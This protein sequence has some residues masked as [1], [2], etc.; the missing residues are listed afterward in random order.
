MS[1]ETVTR[2]P[3]RFVGFVEARYLVYFGAR[4]VSR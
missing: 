4:I 3:I 2:H 1:Y